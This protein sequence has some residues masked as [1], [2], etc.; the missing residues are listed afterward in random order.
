FVS[1]V[2]KGA[3]QCQAEL[4]TLVAA[5]GPDGAVWMNVSEEMRL[6][7]ADRHQV[8]DCLHHTQWLKLW[9]ALSGTRSGGD[10]RMWIQQSLAHLLSCQS[11][12]FPN[13]HLI[14]AKREIGPAGSKLE[15]LS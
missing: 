4:R 14:P 10:S 15:D 6:Q 11:I 13:V 7:Y 3:E 9:R 8:H 5:M 1:A 12:K 2:G